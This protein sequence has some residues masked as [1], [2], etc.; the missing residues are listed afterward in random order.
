MSASI[1]E[2]AALLECP[3][4]CQSFLLQSPAVAERAVCTHCGAHQLLRHASAGE[5]LPHE[6][7]V[8]VEEPRQAVV[9]TLTPALRD[10]HSLPRR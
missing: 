3:V 6:A 2:T 5:P 1:K 9:R 7:E 8:E 4:C 10:R